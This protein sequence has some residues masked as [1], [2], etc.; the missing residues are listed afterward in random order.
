LQGLPKLE[1]V[2]RG[3]QCG[4]RRSCISPGN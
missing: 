1:A 2:G 4:A 3:A